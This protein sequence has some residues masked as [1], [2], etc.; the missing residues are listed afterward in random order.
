MIP[1]SRISRILL[2]LT[3]IFVAL[4]LHGQGRSFLG[5]GAAVTESFDW[6]SSSTLQGLTWEQNSNQPWALPGTTQTGWYAAFNDAPSSFSI[7][8]GTANNGGGMLSNFFYTSGD[9]DRSL[10]GRPTGGRGPLFLALRLTNASDQVLTEFTISYAVEVTRQRDSAINNTVQF[11]YSLEAT[12]A[13]WREA[14]YIDPGEDFHATTPLIPASS[15]VNGNSDTNRTVVGEQTITDISWEPGTDL[16]LRWLAPNVTNGPNIG[17]DDVAFRADADAILPPVRPTGLTVTPVAETTLELAWIDNSADETGFIIERRT[18]DSPFQ[19][20]ATLPADL[21]LFR[22]SGLTPGF[23]YEYRVIADRDGLFSEPSN[24]AAFELLL[25]P[26][27]A[28]AE[29]TS[30]VVSWNTIHLTWVRTDYNADAFQLERS[31]GD[32]NWQTLANIEDL[33]QDTYTDTGLP[34]GSPFSYRIRT[35]N[36]QGS[37]EW[38]SFPQVTTEVYPDTF[39]TG[40]DPIPESAIN[41]TIE[42]N[43]VTGDDDE[44]TGSSEAP[45]RSI[46]EAVE[47]ARTHNAEGRGVKIL[48]HPGTYLEGDPNRDVDFGAVNLSGYWTTEAPLIIEGAGWSESSGHTGDV[49]ITGAE[50]WAGWS[51]KDADGVQSRD[52]P[53][54]WGINPRMTSVAPDVIR[55]FEQVW[56]RTGDGHWHQFIQV[57][58]PDHD[59]VLNNL[60][61]ADGYFWVDEAEDRIHLRPP[62]GMDLNDEETTVHVTTRKRLIHHWRPQSSTTRTPLAIRNLVVEHAGTIGIYTQNMRH[63]TVED[64]VFRRNKIDGFS[65]GS[66]GDVHWTLR[67]CVFHD[68]GTSGFSGGGD[69][70]LG[71]NLDIHNNGRLAYLSNYTGWGNQGM[72]VAEMQYSSLRDWRVWENWG[73]GIWIDTGVMKTEV[74]GAVVWN[75]RSSGIFI[76]N[77]NRNSIEGLGHTPTVMVRDSVFFENTSR[78]TRLLGRG[79]AL[80]ESENV[81]FENVVSVDNER[82]V[83]FSNNVRGDNFRTRIAHSLIGSGTPALNGLYF[84]RNGLG[85]WQEF[86]DTLDGRTND[87]IYV[88]NSPFAFTGRNGEAINFPTW[89]EAQF[90]NPF[91]TSTDKAVDSRSRFIVRDYEGQPLVNIFPVVDSIEEGAPESPAFAIYRLGPDLDQSFEVT[92]SAVSGPGSFDPAEAGQL[93]GEWRQSIIIPAGAT[94][95]LVSLSPAADGRV[96]GRQTLTVAI[97]AG[98]AAFTTRSE[99][100]IVVLDSDAN[101]DASEVFLELPDSLSEGG[102]PVSIGLRRS[103]SVEDPLTVEIG[104]SGDAVLNRDYTVDSLSATFAAGSDFTSLT[105]EPIRD[106]VPEAGKS[107]RIAIE[108]D[109]DGTYLPVTPLEGTI[110]LQDDDLARIEPLDRSAASGESPLPVSLILANPTGESITF[111]L[112][113]PDGQWSVLDSRQEEGPFYDWNEI[114]HPE[115][116]IPM[117]WN[118]DRDDGYSDPLDLGFSVPYYDGTFESVV[119]NSNGFFTFGPLESFFRRFG[120]P[121]PLPVDSSNAPANM[122]AVFW[123][124]FSYPQEAGAYYRADGEQAVITWDRLIKPAD[125][126]MTF[127]ALIRPSGVIKFQYKTVNVSPT[128]SAGLQNSTKS[129]G[130]SLAAS[131]AYAEDGLATLLVPNTAWIET[132]AFPLTI[133]PGEERILALRLLP[134]NLPPGTYRQTLELVPDT[135]ALPVQSETLQIRIADTWFIPEAGWMESSWFGWFYSQN[136]NYL[137]HVDHGLLYTVDSSPDSVYLHDGH[138][139]WLWTSADRYPLLFSYEAGD[140]L[141]YLP[142]T[143]DPRW[144]YD[145]ALG[146]WRSLPAN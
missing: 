46:E 80:S 20:I 141:R 7:N 146:D 83:A 128:P 68:N 144:F 120:L 134:E 111:S 56:V 47:K 36:E 10:G 59:A 126:L 77:N 73:V 139:G 124:D 25:R 38:I 109:P 79:L 48:L 16:W 6:T 58:G 51:V 28:P 86:F 116:A 41:V 117:N 127:Q 131:T 19:P 32:G 102:D 72:K 55:R 100:S 133:A 40:S 64:C 89:Q 95:A 137:R 67:D 97:D 24:E 37:S 99:A 5:A 9:T 129:E 17:L 21:T 39:T 53:Y 82:Q 130:L 123:D 132:P 136:G 81:V 119:V 14:A 54:D 92:L 113:W 142:G 112:R 8:N 44:G 42:V 26:P 43:P 61:E 49:V 138:L 12:E 57:N 4:T 104:V 110:L 118:S 96:E 103:G 52:W 87:N 121:L 107:I 143:N 23:T 85:D 122:V 71:Q 65:N 60:T 35:V 74:V 1:H 69:H 125:R 31:G 93:A 18:G 135:D 30:R 145:Y 98:D 50:E 106:E 70:F 45:L 88:M 33:T 66:F 22:D 75:N 108:P 105:L 15:N 91:N 34:E 140:W 2:I 27:E 90:N 78:G 114:A 29:T 3:T 13:D 101:P 62:D 84:P 63:I 94:R 115:N 11:G 76:E